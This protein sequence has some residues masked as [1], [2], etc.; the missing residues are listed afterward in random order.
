[1]NQ[2]DFGAGR[3]YGSTYEASVTP[4][5]AVID[6]YISMQWSN[7]P[8]A[9][10]DGRIVLEG[11]VI[12]PEITT[13]DLN[14]STRSRLGHVRPIIAG[15]IALK[16]AV[17]NLHICTNGIY[18]SG[19]IYGRAVRGSVALECA[20]MNLHIGAL[21]INSASIWDIVALEGA[22]MNLH[23]GTRNINSPTIISAAI[24][25]RCRAI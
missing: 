8:A 21:S 1:L 13:L 19:G 24:A 22:V 23:V 18:S 2:E 12:N 11:A 10:S 17:V 15:S 20:V 7:S 16:C 6:L 25:K 14:S 9:V 3:I 4:E 5:G